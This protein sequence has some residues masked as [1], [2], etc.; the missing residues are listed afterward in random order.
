[1]NGTGI[2]SNLWVK[3]RDDD[4]DEENNIIVLRDGNGQRG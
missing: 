1:M 2:E 3:L 4:N